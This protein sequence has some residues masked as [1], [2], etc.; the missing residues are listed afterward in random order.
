MVLTLKFD[1]PAA[2]TDGTV[3]GFRVA[4]QLKCY[5]GVAVPSIALL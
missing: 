4:V 5:R 1:W 2:V 3:N